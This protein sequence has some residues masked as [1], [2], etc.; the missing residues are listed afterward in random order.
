MSTDHDKEAVLK[1]CDFGQSKMLYK[2]EYTVATNV[3]SNRKMF[4]F[5][6]FGG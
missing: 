2:G 5:V 3:N 1:I 4:R 6:P